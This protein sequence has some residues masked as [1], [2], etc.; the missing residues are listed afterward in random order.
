MQ[1]NFGRM[2]AIKERVKEKGSTSNGGLKVDLANLIY[3]FVLHECG[4]LCWE[5]RKE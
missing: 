4:V 1:V 3:T 2:L 5:N